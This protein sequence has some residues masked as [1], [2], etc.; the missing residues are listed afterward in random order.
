M[1]SATPPTAPTAAPAPTATPPSTDPKTLD[2]VL[3]AEFDH[4]VR[5]RHLGRA[6]SDVKHNL[7]GLALSGGGIRSATTNLGV[8][9]ALS[10]LGVLPLVDYLSTVSG[11]G[12][13]GACLSSL[14]SWNGDEPASRTPGSHEPFTFSSD[15]L[16]FTTDWKHF[17]FR[18]EYL[19]GQS[20]VGGDLVAHLRTHG[21][22]LV[23]RLGLLTRE[24]MRS[25]GNIITGVA[26]NVLAF[27]LTMFAIAA[28]YMSTAL[29]IAP[30]IRGALNGSLGRPSTPA[31]VRP[32]SLVDVD[33]TTTRVD[34]AHG[35]C[36]ANA[37]GCVQETRT[38][39]H[40]PTLLDRV[41]RNATVTGIVFASAAAEW[42]ACAPG[43]LPDRMGAILIAL[44]IGALF[45]IAIFIWILIARRQYIKGISPIGGEPKRGESIE[46]ALE[47][48]V[49]RRIA[50]FALLTALG[51]LALVR[52]L[53]A[54]LH[55][56]AQLIWLFVPVAV[57]AA[58]RFTSFFL[59]VAVLPAMA[60][61]TRRLRSLWGA[62][63]TI[64]IY[65]FWVFFVAAVFPLAVYALR[66]HSLAVGWSA[67]GSLLVT[68]FVVRRSTGGGA[69]WL[70]KLSGQ[71]R[72]IVLGVLVTLAVATCIL[73]FGSLLAAYADSAMQSLMFTGGSA[74]VLILF[75]L[76]A[77]QNKLGP[78]YF[79]RDRIAE[80][81]LLS[82]L[83]DA[84]GAM[85]VYRDAMEMPL[86]ALHGEPAPTNKGWRNT[87][88]YHL[89][90]AAINLAG[91]RDLTRKD[92][93]SGY[94]LFSKLF[95][96]S[97]HT[98]FRETKHYRGGETKLA[99]AI[100]I[101]GAAA[102]SGIGQDTFFAQAFATVMFNIRLGYWLQNPMHKASITDKEGGTFWPWYLWREVTMNTTETAGLVNLSDGG[103]TGD[104]VGI[105]PLLQ[106]R[107]K[108]IIACDAEQDPALT[109]S[110]FTEALRHAYVDL[111]IDVDI[112]L[113][114]IRPDPVSGLSRS[115]CAVGRIR[116]PDRPDQESYLIYIKNSL[117]GD[118][119]EPVLNYKAR[120]ADFP[121]ETTVDQFFDDAQF[122]SYRA[123][124]VHLTEHT[125]AGWV[126]S[127]AFSKVLNTNSPRR[128][129]IA[130]EPR[131]RPFN[132]PGQAFEFTND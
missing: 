70:K 66:D 40:P 87:A 48:R 128:V 77:D 121:H 29:S 3:Q 101:S 32:R 64:T 8:L 123:L 98:G 104:N 115:H 126:I 102:S 16:R 84:D 22:F 118:E 103:H 75:A 28:I 62:Y 50:V 88:P 122:E 56:D 124:G 21:N 125:F 90:S 57:F 41:K 61:W 79:Y 25:I 12:Y 86:S 99:R 94:W 127:P 13:I 97:T 63:Q 27:L 131:D 39:L 42:A 35:T 112:D 78:Q 43:C 7:I 18:A 110:S 59:A 85:R 33:S 37:P 74:G 114:M 109:F 2:D 82:E 36:A 44:A 1:T 53:R 72:N 31:D 24:T 20:K 108:V 65:G 107:C 58:A 55:G 51:T 91:S 111:K 116:Y 60:I 38:T 9:Q 11:G 17:P 71:F 46:D 73:F 10:R 15:E 96:G 47:G 113:T 45:S 68:R 95:C 4:I 129:P 132:P 89:V 23:S 52:W 119:P 117:T 26:F 14:L 6:R 83:A 106:R 81:Y 130:G 69:S 105:Y 19:R 92:R 67:F 100:A 80:T 49:L 93:K 54:P 76:F 34:T 30:D 5:N 120:H